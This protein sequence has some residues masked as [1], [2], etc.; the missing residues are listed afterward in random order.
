[1]HPMIHVIVSSI[2]ADVIGI[3]F[4]VG[5]KKKNAIEARKNRNHIDGNQKKDKPYYRK[6]NTPEFFPQPQ[7]ASEMLNFVLFLE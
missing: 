7:T 3:V 4:V 2:M 1:M 6:I 5:L